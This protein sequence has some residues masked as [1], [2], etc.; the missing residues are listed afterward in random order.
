MS[1]NQTSNWPEGVDPVTLADLQLCR[2][3]E[4]RDW[5]A[6]GVSPLSLEWDELIA[7][8]RSKRIEHF[9]YLRLGFML[10]LEDRD[11]KVSEEARRVARHGEVISDN[12]DGDAVIGFASEKDQ[13][14]FLH[15]CAAFAAGDVKPN[16]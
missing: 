7:G 16:A 1:N 14:S 13:K 2:E 11:I 3:K 12:L 6:P 4:Q 8:A 10:D 9:V 15:W 5:P